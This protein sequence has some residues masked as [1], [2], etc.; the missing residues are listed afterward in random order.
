MREIH[1]YPDTGGAIELGRN[2]PDNTLSVHVYRHG[3]SATITLNRQELA[4][5]L[6]ALSNELEHLQKTTATPPERT[7]KDANH[8]QP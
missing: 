5:L 7:R 6:Y 1:I 4:A 3:R 8:P 2:A